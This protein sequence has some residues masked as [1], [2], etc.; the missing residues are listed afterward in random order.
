MNAQSCLSD[1]LLF[2]SAVAFALRFSAHSRSRSAL[3]NRRS[4][5]VVIWLSPV[6]DS[7]AQAF[8]CARLRRCF[9]DSRGSLRAQIGI[10]SHMCPDP[11]PFRDVYEDLPT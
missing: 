10:A 9:L 5:Y 7:S 3:A 11:P 2:R 8:T 6:C 1:G 4:R